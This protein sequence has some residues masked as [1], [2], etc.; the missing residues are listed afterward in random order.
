MLYCLYL[1]KNIFNVNMIWER[2][3]LKWLVIIFILVNWNLL[4]GVISNL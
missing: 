2:L 4:F 3:I 1:L